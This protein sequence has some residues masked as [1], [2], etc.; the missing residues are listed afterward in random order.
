[1]IAR[2]IF[3]NKFEKN[4]NRKVKQRPVLLYFTRL[5]C[6][7]Y[8]RELDFDNK[9]EGAYFKFSKGHIEDGQGHVKPFSFV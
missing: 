8:C 6:L 3:P 1:M 9:D 5:L 2:I 4:G 7:A